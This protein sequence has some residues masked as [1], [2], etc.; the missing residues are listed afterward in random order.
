[1]KSY[2]L[3]ILLAIVLSLNTSILFSQN[4]F[5]SSNTLRYADYLFKSANYKDV[6]EEY[7]RLVYMYNVDE[8]V[9]LRLIQSYRFNR[10][11]EISL[12]R[13][14]TLWA[15]P[16]NVSKNVSREFFNLK[17]INRQFDSIETKI[18]RNKFL[19]DFD[20]NFY[21]A[22]SLLLK[23]D[24]KGAKEF[25]ETINYTE[26]TTLNT[27]HSLATEASK[28]KMKSPFLSGALSAIIPG[29]GKF[30][31]GYWQDGLIS[32]TIV[33]TSAWQ[34]YRGFN[35]QG[36][37]SGYGWVF[38]LLGTGFYLGNIYGSIK[39]ANKYNHEKKDKIRIKIEATFYNNILPY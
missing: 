20:K 23:D 3:Y 11:P 1:M 19:T 32:F 12:H 21:Y 28:Q 9:K 22:S 24:F 5:D 30:Y 26:N 16:E 38:G 36:I 39:S 25:L 2:K 14:N 33:G 4:L 7:E 34:S 17:I 10:Q 6:I 8:P 18:S 35:K 37:K 29:S 13:M 31:T 27:Y 15:N